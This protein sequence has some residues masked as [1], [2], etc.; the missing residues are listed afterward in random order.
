MNNTDHD[1][2]KAELMVI[3]EKISA[4]Q[5]AAQASL[6]EH[7]MMFNDAV[8]AII[9]TIMILEVPL[10]VSSGSSYTS[11][12]RAILVFLISFFIVANFW[13]AHHRAMSGLNFEKKS[14][15]ILNFTFL[16]GLSIIP[17]LTKWL[18][19]EPT[20]LAV[21]NYGT[22]YLFINLI[23]G[24]IS[25]R[26]HTDVLAE[27]PTALE[28]AR[29]ILHLRLVSLLLW[30]IVLIVLAYFIPNVVMIFY[31]SL[32]VLNFLWPFDKRPNSRPHNRKGKFG[33]PQN[34]GHE[35][36]RHER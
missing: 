9:S 11:F 32:P 36:R 31:I 30:N 35:R 29:Q 12:L 17:L 2:N 21:I 3:R 4:S 20:R 14:T 28:F 26:S 13:Y 34:E 6:K 16:A 33:R 5:D 22:T 15:L 25:A 24:I 8:I 27:H 19:L 10:P 1:H 7:I 18:M 23:E